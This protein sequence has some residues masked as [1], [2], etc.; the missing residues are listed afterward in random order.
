MSLQGFTPP[1]TAALTGVAYWF[2]AFAIPNANHTATNLVPGRLTVTVT[3]IML[4]GVLIA[5]V[6]GAWVY[7]EQTV[8]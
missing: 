4:F 5:S 6:C 2:F 8:G 7:K 3:F 1:K